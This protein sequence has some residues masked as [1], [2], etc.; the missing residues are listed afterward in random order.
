MQNV[1]TAT[2]RQTFI[3]T[4]QVTDGVFCNVATGANTAK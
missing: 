2:Y 1:K 3:G 4:M